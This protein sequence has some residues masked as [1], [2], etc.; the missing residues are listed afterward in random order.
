MSGFC[1]GSNPCVM[2]TRPNNSG[3]AIG[4]HGMTMS[5]GPGAKGATRETHTKREKMNTNEKK[6][7]RGGGTTLFKYP[8]GGPIRYIPIMSLSLN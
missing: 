2:I 5:R 1:M 3:V 6:K 4:W 8:D 7:K